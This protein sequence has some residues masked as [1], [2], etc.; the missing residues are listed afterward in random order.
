MKKGLVESPEQWRWSSYRFYV[1]AK[2]GPVRINEGWTKISFRE[3]KVFC[4]T[5]PFIEPAQ[6]PFSEGQGLLSSWL[7]KIEQDSTNASRKF[8]GELCS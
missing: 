3:G 8:G 5:S 4:L 6:L 2:A 1:L 7:L